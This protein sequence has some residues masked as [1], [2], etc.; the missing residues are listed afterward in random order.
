M[1]AKRSEETEACGVC[2]RRL[3]RE[4]VRLPQR[5]VARRSGIRIRPGD[6]KPAHSERKQL[7]C[8]NPSGIRHIAGVRRPCTLGATSGRSFISDE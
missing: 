2:V 1:C 7:V 5:K 8:D 3:A 6:G 4:I